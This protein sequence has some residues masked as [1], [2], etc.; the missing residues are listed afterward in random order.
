M[1]SF[2]SYLVAVLLT[3]YTTFLKSYPSS[4]ICYSRPPMFIINSL[5][6]IAMNGGILQVC[7]KRIERPAES[8][9]SQSLS[10]LKRQILGYN[11]DVHPSF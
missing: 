7:D 1:N 6:Q 3:E 5:T 8:H 2:F 11:Y 9:V 4:Q 10:L